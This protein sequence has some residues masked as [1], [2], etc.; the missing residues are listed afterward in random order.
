MHIERS[1]LSRR[2][3]EFQR[4]IVLSEILLSMLIGNLLLKEDGELHGSQLP[5]LTR[6]RI[7]PI[8][9]TRRMKFVEH[10][11]DHLQVLVFQA[12]GFPRVQDRCCI[13]RMSK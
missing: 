7:V 8:E 13:A 10:F 11:A 1:I 12:L 3:G 2:P 5:H 6:R 4:M 9:E